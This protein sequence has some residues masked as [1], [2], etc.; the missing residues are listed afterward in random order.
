VTVRAEDAA[1]ARGRKRLLVKIG[2][3]GIL[4]LRR[5]PS[6]NLA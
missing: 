3:I 2:P 5:Y 1:R 4:F 6:T